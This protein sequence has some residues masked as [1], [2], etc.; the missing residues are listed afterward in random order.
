M[1]K[2]INFDS[3]VKYH[4]SFHSELDLSSLK[5]LEHNI[6]FGLIKDFK[7][8]DDQVLFFWT[9]GE[10]SDMVSKSNLTKQKLIDLV[11]SL[12]SKIANELFVYME[13]VYY[14]DNET[15]IKGLELE[16][17]DKA[18]RLFK[19]VDKN[20]TAFSYD[21]FK[22][23]KSVYSKNLFRLLSQYSVIGKLK[24]DYQ[25]ARKILCVSDNYNFS[26]FNRVVLSS[27]I[28]ELANIFKRL[29]VEL[30]KDREEGDTVYKFLVFSFAPFRTQ[31]MIVRSKNQ[32]ELIAVNILLKYI[33]NNNAKNKAECQEIIELLKELKFDLYKEDSGIYNN[34]INFKLVRL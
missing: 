5:V 8:N 11:N 12:K 34:D 17:N 20:F 33:N 30:I 3:M 27:S 29:N 32:R 21:E 24:I 6:L 31:R 15:K 25:L 13:F 2:I 18:I 1:K 14:D 7:Y 10:L 4:N 22:E 28:T 16:I 23:L 19:G 26:T 9:L